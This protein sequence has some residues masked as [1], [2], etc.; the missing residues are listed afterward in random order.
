MG[1]RSKLTNEMIDAVMR[2]LPV[3]WKVYTYQSGDIEVEPVNPRVIRDA[4]AKGLAKALELYDQ[5]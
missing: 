1:R 4:I 3:A 5:A 2:E